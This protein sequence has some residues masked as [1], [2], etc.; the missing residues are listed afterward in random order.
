MTCERCAVTSDATTAPRGALRPARIL[1]L[2]CLPGILSLPL[3]L[4]HTPGVRPTAALLLQPAV[5]LVIAASGE[6]GSAPVPAFIS[7]PSCGHLACRAGGN[8]CIAR[9][10]NRGR[11]L[12]PAWPL[13]NRAELAPSIIEA[14]NL[15][16]FVVG[17]LYGGIVEE[18]MFRWFVMSLF[19]VVCSFAASPAGPRGNRAGSCPPR[20]WGPPRCLPQ[21][22]CPGSLVDGSMPADGVVVRALFLNGF[23]GIAFGLLFARRDLVAAMLAHAG[24]HLGF[25]TAAL[26]V[27]IW[28]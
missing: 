2:A 9:R 13:A 17:L 18:V 27:E 28:P 23:A 6:A 20:R 25:A 14:W 10:R 15:R 7:R 19:A 8:G 12:W 1:L 26:T 21:A 3:V 4:P 5:L 11:R 22:I 16:G 24:T